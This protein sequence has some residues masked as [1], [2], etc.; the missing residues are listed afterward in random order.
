[1]DEKLSV[2]RI[3][4]PVKTLG[5]GNR[6]GI[7]TTGCS[8]N[9]PGCISPEL[10]AY[11]PEKEL[12]VEDIIELIRSIPHPIDGFTISGGE[13][14]FNP[15]GLD[16]LVRELVKINDDVLIYTGYTLRELKESSVP[17]IES[18]LERCAVL[19]DGPYREELNDNCGLRG[20]SNQCIHIFRYPD[21]Y[22]GLEWEDRKIQ[23]VVYGNGVLMIGIPGRNS[24]DQSG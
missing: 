21:K 4:Y 20:S 16:A 8:K 7:W 10:Q 12:A 2:A 13:P 6:I 9:C 15:S 17:Q 23:N 19:I 3:Y 22:R 1:M 18:I 5:P 14:F 24:N 11:D